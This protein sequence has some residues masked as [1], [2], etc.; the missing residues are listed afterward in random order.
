MARTPVEP[1]KQTMF[2]LP[3]SD[4][5]PVAVK[6][7]WAA[8]GI[9]FLLLLGAILFARDFLMPVT[10][11]L[12]LFFVFSPL[13]RRLGRRGIP[14]WVTATLVVFALLALM[15]GVVLSVMSPVGQMIS[16]APSISRKLETK[17]QELKDSVKGIQEVATKIDNVTAG[18]TPEP[19][20]VKTEETR[21]SFAMSVASAAPGLIG[22][23]LFVLILMFFMLTSGDLLY[24]KIVQSFDTLKEKRAAYQALREIEENLGS[25]LGTISLIN[26]GLGVAIGSAF[27][28]LDMPAPFLFGVLASL[29]NFIPYIGAFIAA[30]LSVA[31]ALVTMDGFFWPAMVGVTYI[32]I[33]SIEGQFVTP[34]FLSRRLEL[35]T[36]VVFIAV[37][38]WAWLWN[39]VGMIVAV[40]ILVM[41]RVLC[42]HVPGLEKVANFL[43]GE[44]APAVPEEDH[45]PAPAAPPAPVPAPA[46]AS[47]DT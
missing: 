40:P 28:A 32:G 26:L 39:I 6:P 10:M 18:A 25:Y 15:G 37:A 46:P 9:F 43:G 36:V 27:W 35:N 8:V 7:S 30:G 16:D 44:D 12:L 2:Y 23:F 22:Q 34:Y 5:K 11:S 45:E 1:R 20:V 19:G 47:T 21:G 31:V 24:L 29:A 3:V 17:F 38:L 33:N 14:A 41:I 4:T 13:V 42:E